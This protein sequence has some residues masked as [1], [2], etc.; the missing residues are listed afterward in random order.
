MQI[1]NR[2]SPEQC[3]G[4]DDIRAEIDLLDHNGPSR[5]VS[6]LTPLGGIMQI[7]GIGGELHIALLHK[8]P[9]Q[10]VAQPD[11]HVRV[12]VK[13]AL[14]SVE[15]SNAWLEWPVVHA[16]IAE[17]EALNRTLFGKAELV[18]MSPGNFALAIENLDS[19]GHIGVSFTVGAIGIT[20]NGQ[21]PASVSGGFEI[22]PSE[23]ES[24]LVWFQSIVANEAAA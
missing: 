17:L 23:L 15:R 1:E 10:S 7:R 14:F 22:L 16:F 11:L 19:K 24:L 13:T 2:L 3:A 18:A 8:A 4:M 20:D 6:A 21:F 5:T 12:Q 9:S